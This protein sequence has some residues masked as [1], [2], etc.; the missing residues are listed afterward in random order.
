MAREIFDFES[1][2]SA[3]SRFPMTLIYIT[4][5]NFYKLFLLFFKIFT[6]VCYFFGFMS[7]T[8]NYLPLRFFLRGNNIMKPTYVRLLEHNL[9][10]FNPLKDFLCIN[11][12]PKLFPYLSFH[13]CFLRTIFFWIGRGVGFSHEL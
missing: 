10:S 11:N 13:F 5:E 9:T 4:T 8:S 12:I 1:P 7:N 2:D 6:F 3:I